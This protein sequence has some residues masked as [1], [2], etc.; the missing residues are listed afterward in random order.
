MKAKTMELLREW[1]MTEH[2]YREVLDFTTHIDDGPTEEELR[3]FDAIHEVR[4]QCTNLTERLHKKMK[5]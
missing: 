5:I 3:E 1:D 2:V 4:G